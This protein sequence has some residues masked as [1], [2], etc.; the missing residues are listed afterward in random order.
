MS[1]AG[2]A[3]LA[4]A[5]VGWGSLAVSTTIALRGIGPLNLLL[6]EV[7]VASAVLLIATVAAG[8]A[9]PRLSWRVLALGLLQPGVA[10]TTFN[11]GVQRTSAADAGLL[12]G[13]EAVFTILLAV[14][15][16]G[17]RP[18]RRIFA[19]VSLGLMGV[20]VMSLQP[21]GHATLLG[22]GLVLLDSLAAAG[23]VILASGLLATADP[24]PLTAGQF[25]VGLVVI[26]P[27]TGI[28]WITGAEH[29]PTLP[30]L[31]PLVAL[32]ATGAVGTAASFL[33][34]TW[35]LKRVR[36]SVAAIAVPLT[37]LA[38]LALSV[39]VLA[40]PVTVTAALAAT[41]IV[42]GLCVF[43]T[44]KSSD[45]RHQSPPTAPR[46]RARGVVRSRVA[47]SICRDDAP[48][49]SDRRTT[50]RA[51]G[52]ASPNSSVVL[53]RGGAREA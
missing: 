48:S 18:G 53:G 45:Q 22:D 35:A 15:V 8:R 52:D 43:A 4:G 17:E 1:R 9:L 7:G 42:S 24:L 44:G 50:G 37:P 28:G 23:A 31:E 36:P 26:I 39:T 34:Y 12:L 38:T 51:P 21:G 16:L 46:R 27:V 49:R 13:M 20:A 11:F 3:A 41:M 47:C 2:L 40:E 6:G 25:L 33:A 5:A 19:G 10:Y 14:L 30:A 29:L 32:I